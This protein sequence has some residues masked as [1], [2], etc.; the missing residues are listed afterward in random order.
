MLNPVYERNSTWATVFLARMVAVAEAAMWEEVKKMPAA[1]AE[2]W[3]EQHKEELEVLSHSK[4]WTITQVPPERQ[5]D[6]HAHSQCRWGN[7]A[8]KG[9]QPASGYPQKYG[10]DGKEKPLPSE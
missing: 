3:K 5:T 6:L 2:K 9:G 7:P 10:K 4:S 1:E 8:Y